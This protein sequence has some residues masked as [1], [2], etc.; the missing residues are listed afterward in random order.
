PGETRAIVLARRYDSRGAALTR[1][2]VVHQPSS[3]SRH[4][5]RIAA[6]PDGGMVVAWSADRTAGAQGPRSLT[7]RFFAPDGTP[8]SDELS[9]DREVAVGRNAATGIAV[10]P[11][12]SA[13]IAGSSDAGATVQNVAPDGTVGPYLGL[14]TPECAST[15]GFDMAEEPA[16]AMRPDGSF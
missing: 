13:W 7:A 6:T 15:D 5:A 8:R 4:F 14:C 3:L 1:P 9:L 12:G 16:L 10:E 2:F 11:N